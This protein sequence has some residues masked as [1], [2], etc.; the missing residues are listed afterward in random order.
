M[1][2][3]A[4]LETTT[5]PRIRR[6]KALPPCVPPAQYDSGEHADHDAGQYKGP[7]NRDRHPL[8]NDSIGVWIERKSDEHPEEAKHYSKHRPTNDRCGDD[9]SQSDLTPAARSSGSLK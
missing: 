6:S 2:W 8:S 9:S 7:E 5:A 3:L 4:S 1:G